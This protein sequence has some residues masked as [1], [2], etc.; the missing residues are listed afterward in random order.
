MT[1]A[2][3][4][5][6]FKHDWAEPFKVTRESNTDVQHAFDGTEVR[7][8]LRENPNISLAMRCVFL[9]EMGAGRLLTQW[10]AATRPLLYYAPLWCDVTDLT[11]AVTAGDAIV[12]LDTTTRPFFALDGT[13]T[14]YAMLWRSEEFAEVVS[15]SEVEDSLIVLTAGTTNSYAI[16]GTRVVPVRPMWLTMPV[17]VT[18]R[19]ARI[20]DVSL[21]FTDAKPQ[22][23]LGY[24]GASTTA[25]PDH[26]RVWRSRE[27]AETPSGYHRTLQAVVFDAA[28][29]PI[30]SARV[31]WAVDD[32]DV[33]IT[34]DMS[35]LSARE[36]AATASTTFQITVACGDVELVTTNPLPIGGG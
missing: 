15:Y 12:E 23:A 8:R 18:W 28:D 11:T 35:T 27:Y 2:P 31:S 4:L 25:V 1:L 7:I 19:S 21:S 3:T 24:T 32:V 16:A 33:T 30:P 13:G 17:A 22:A 26:I 29:N 5:F 34:P 14:G 6:P 9:T 36:Y 10:R 20:A